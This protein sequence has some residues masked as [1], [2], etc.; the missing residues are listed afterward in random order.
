MLT[1]VQF[2]C[3]QLAGRMCLRHNKLSEPSRCS[4]LIVESQF[5][6]CACILNN[7]HPVPILSQ[8]SHETLLV[9]IWAL[10]CQAMLGFKQ[11][12]TTEGRNLCRMSADMMDTIPRYPGIPVHLIRFQM[13]R[14]IINA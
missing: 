14:S 8:C 6:V 9:E 1:C 13:S 5:Q 7:S 11:A 3:L 12:R 2:I 4:P 10:C